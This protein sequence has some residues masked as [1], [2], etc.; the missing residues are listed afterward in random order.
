MSFAAD[1][2]MLT[3][4]KV[5]EVAEAEVDVIVLTGVVI[6]RAHLGFWFAGNEGAKDFASVSKLPLP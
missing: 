4:K 5:T 1:G 2:S 3:P 6:K